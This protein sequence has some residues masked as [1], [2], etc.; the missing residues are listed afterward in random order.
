MS[1]VITYAKLRLYLH[2]LQKIVREVGLQILKRPDGEN[3]ADT[4][5]H[6][7]HESSTVD[8]T[9]RDLFQRALDHH[10]PDF[11]GV[12]KFELN[13]Y[14]REKL[15]PDKHKAFAVIVDEIDGTTN[16]KRCFASQLHY[17]PTAAISV[18]LCVGETLEHLVIGVIYTLDT[19]EVFSAIK[20]NDEE[21]FALHDDKLIWPSDIIETRGDSRERIIV[22]GYSNSFRHHKADAEDALIAK[23]IKVYDGSRSSAM[24]VINVIRNQYDAYVDLRHYWSTKDEKG[25]EKEAMLQVYD[26]AGVIPIAIGCGLTVTDALGNPW[27]DYSF[28]Y[29]IPIV[30]ARPGIHAK[31]IE[32]LKPVIEAWL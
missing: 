26:I 30:I 1:E 23:R 9:A 32:A 17:R 18:A 10:F 16:A 2:A 19:G 5:D 29:S 20:V 3:I 4:H 15:D 8:I 7:G 22:A 14:R 28:H 11:E 12:V 25:H 6:F 27:Q 24:D 21:F 31:I 13:P